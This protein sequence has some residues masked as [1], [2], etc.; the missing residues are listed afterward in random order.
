MITVPAIIQV[1]HDPEEMW[2]SNNPVLLA[3]EEGVIIGGVNHGRRKTGDGVRR[4]A[5]LPFTLGADGVGIVSIEI[6]YRSLNQGHTPPEDTEWDSSIPE[7]PAG[8]FLWTR[9]RITKTNDSRVDAFT[10]S[11]QDTDGHRIITI[12][13]TDPSPNTRIGD[14]LLNGTN[15]PIINRGFV[16]L[17]TGQIEPGIL[18][19]RS[20]AQLVMAWQD[21]H[22]VH[23]LDPRSVTS[24]SEIHLISSA[25]DLISRMPPMVLGDWVVNATD[26]AITGFPLGNSDV[27]EDSGT[28]VGE[29]PPRSMARLMTTL[30]NQVRVLTIRAGSIIGGNSKLNTSELPDNIVL[31]N[32]ENIFS[33]NQQFGNAAVGGVLTATRIEATHSLKVFGDNVATV[34]DLKNAMLATQQWLPAVQT[35]NQLR[36]TGL[37]KEVNY[38]CKVLNDTPD[39]NGVWQAI[40]GWV[41]APVWRYFSD[42]A[43]GVNSLEL[44]NAISQHDE[45]SYAHAALLDGKSNVEHTHVPSQ[46]G[47]GNVTN[48]AQVRRNEMGAANGVATLDGSGRVPM[49]QLPNIGGGGSPS[50][51][52]RYEILTASAN[53]NTAANRHSFIMPIH[54]NTANPQHFRLERPNFNPLWFSLVFDFQGDFI[55]GFKKDVFLEFAFAGMG[56][57]NFQLGTLGILGN[58]Q[59]RLNGRQFPCN[60]HREARWLL[61][62]NVIGLMNHSRGFGRRISGREIDLS[63][64]IFWGVQEI[65]RTDTRR[66]LH[67]SGRAAIEARARANTFDRQMLFHIM[68]EYY[69]PEIKIMRAT[70]YYN[71]HI[72]NT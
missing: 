16:N 40:A 21:S 63:S 6:G 61:R 72:E 60:L 22:M 31:T 45:S 32:K 13:D 34:F 68:I 51:P 15:R 17:E 28:A 10:V 12:T 19:P 26:N 11:R 27:V 23:A 49:A 2:N 64:I 67:N 43:E 3:G 66:N 56:S 69:S 59:L 8:R 36:R 37:F 20:M 44:K 46:A 24:S 4:W 18:Q 7:V 9:F 54:L 50:L 25:G 57:I 52:L 65:M 35:V 38:L 58:I 14:W 29:L 42:N 53:A 48:H 71:G 41:D 1:R 39:N 30:V 55:P 47:L 62:D 70:G 5:E 33:E